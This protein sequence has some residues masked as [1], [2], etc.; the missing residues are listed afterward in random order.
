MTIYVDPLH[1][2]GF[3]G[4]WCHMAGDSLEEL[5]AMAER[6]GLRREWFQDKPRF[7]H[8]DIHWFGRQKAIELGAWEV[9]SMQMAHIFTRHRAK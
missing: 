4:E 9:T 1:H 8:Y 3:K 2:Y 5:H 7:P 6:I